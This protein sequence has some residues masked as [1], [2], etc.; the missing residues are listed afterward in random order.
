MSAI[1]V[2]QDRPHP[3]KAAE[4]IALMKEAKQMAAKHGLSH[5]LYLSVL[6]GPIVGVYS[7][8]LEAADLAT[9]AA[10]IQSML[11]DPA[12][13]DLGNRVREV[14]AL[15]NLSQATEVPL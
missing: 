3:G 12:N 15:I 6:A 1:A 4:F 2:V 8:V 9:L 13:T 14:A 10:G 11:A 5:R 7:S